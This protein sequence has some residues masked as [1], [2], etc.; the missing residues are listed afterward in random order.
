MDSTALSQITWQDVQEAPDDGDR[1]EATE[2]ELHVTAALEELGDERPSLGNHPDLLAAV[3]RSRVHRHVAVQKLEAVVP[4]LVAIGGV[5]DGTV[6]V[7]ARPT[8]SRYPGLQRRRNPRFRQHLPTVPP[9]TVQI[10]VSEFSACRA[11]GARASR[12]GAPTASC[13]RVRRRPRRRPDGRPRPADRSS[14][15]AGGPGARRGA[16]G[17]RR[18]T[19]AP[20]SGG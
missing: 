13:A 11:G 3:S 14:P 1:W 20:S 10:Q 6:R 5:P 17:R 12:P 7:L 9:S 8:R 2:A 4:P 15:P 16:P 19:P 18:R